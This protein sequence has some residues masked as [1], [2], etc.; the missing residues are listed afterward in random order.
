MEK[1]QVL[2]V[3]GAGMEN[4]LD[5]VIRQLPDLKIIE[6][7]KGL[8][9]IKGSGH[10]HDEEINQMEHDDHEGEVNAHIWVSISGAIGEVKNIR[11]QLAELDPA[12]AESYRTNADKYIS[13]LEELRSRMHQ[14][15]DGIENRKIITFHEAF[16]YFAQEFDLDIAAVIQR[17]PGSEP[18]PKEIAA[19]IELIREHG[20]KAIFAEPQYSPLAAEAIARETTAKVYTLDPAV[21]GEM[22]PDAYLKAMEANLLTLTEAL[23]E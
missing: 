13:K 16:P 20:I 23:A 15:L 3:N 22:E 9:F 8:S 14:T 18:S 6:A 4:Y 11:D 12:Y 21:T 1:T 5:R 2:V 7:S 17:E 19:S 10:D